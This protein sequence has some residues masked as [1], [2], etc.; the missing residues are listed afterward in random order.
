MVNRHRIPVAKYARR[1]T[2]LLAGLILAAVC[3]PG[4][5][6]PETTGV[7][8]TVWNV[9]ERL[10]D[11][12]TRAELESLTREDALAELS[13]DERRVLGTQFVQFN[14]NVPVVVSVIRDPGPEPEFWLEDL[15]FTKTDLVAEI[16]HEVPWEVWQAEF[17][18]GEIGLGVNGIANATANYSVESYALAVAPADPDDVLEISD[19]YHPSYGLTTLELGEPAWADEPSRYFEEVPPEL[20][21]HQL[22]QLLRTRRLDGELV[23]FAT[24]TDHVS[25]P[26]PDQ[27]VVTPGESPSRSATIQWR[28]SPETTTSYVRYRMKQASGRYKVEAGDTPVVIDSPRDDILGNVD[29]IEDYDGGLLDLRPE[30]ANDPVVNRHIVHLDR[31][32]PGK[33]YVY[34]VGDGTEDGWSEPQEF[35]TAPAGRQPF[36]FLYMGDVQ[37]GFE[38]WSDIVQGAHARH[39][40]A[41]FVVMAGDL[42]N[43][44]QRRHEWDAFFNAS[45]GV[46]SNQPIVP[47]LGNHE[48]NGL[49]P[50][51]YLDQFALI[52]NGPPGLEERVYSFE[53]GDA[54][55]AVLDANLKSESEL[56]AQA[57]WLADQLAQTSATWKVVVQHQPIYGS[58]PSQDEPELRAAWAPVYDRY[59]VDLVLQ[60]H[61][62]GYLRTHPM[63]DGKIVEPGSSEQGTIYLVTNAG[64]KYY[65]AGGFEEKYGVE[66]AVLFG[67]VSTYQAID[68]DRRELR[69][70]AYDADGN[71]V[72]QFELSKQNGKAPR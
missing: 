33:T 43:E 54:F 41:E 15:G 18:A 39:P 37:H 40:E 50:S 9:Q 38:G 13:A 47:A 16:R 12:L 7:R 67:D 20:D 24:F 4:Y 45:E 65:E 23:E 63:K 48:Y 42:V 57:D 44:G 17:P 29:D 11:E 62:H 10:L 55:F 36:S 56:Q 61:T 3:V 2:A 66:P 14:V 64:D 59:D 52:E 22:V 8:E 19:L 51:M 69:Y 30:P 28:T 5:A 6:E 53:R 71:I 60:G 35:T 58:R 32:V 34:S 25:S 46:F 68:V 49:P 31:L 72:D 70:R 21:G 26:R 1:A 27:I